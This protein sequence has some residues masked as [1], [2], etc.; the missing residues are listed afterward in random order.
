MMMLIISYRKKTGVILI[1]A[2]AWLIFLTYARCSSDRHHGKQS[3]RIFL[4]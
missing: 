4:R 2:F 1:T 3:E